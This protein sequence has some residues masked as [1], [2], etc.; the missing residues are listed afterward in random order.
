MRIRKERKRRTFSDAGP[1]DQREP[2]G[3]PS[4]QT[5][6]AEPERKKQ[7]LGLDTGDMAK[8]E[9][10]AQQA[11]GDP[12]L[13]H[14]MTDLLAAQQRLTSHLEKMAPP[15]GVKDPVSKE[16][17]QRM[18]QDHVDKERDREQEFQRMKDE[19]RERLHANMK[20][21]SRH[22]RSLPGHW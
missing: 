20:S 8:L 14:L 2:Q 4:H 13:A 18:S 16:D 17:I 6:E 9:A 15:D 19:R 5:E 7:A 21:L 10:T 1:P 12:A 11:Q 22:G 3:P